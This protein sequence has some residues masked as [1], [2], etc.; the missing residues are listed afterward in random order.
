D[1]RTTKDLLAQCLDWSPLLDALPEDQKSVVQPI[2]RAIA[3]RLVKQPDFK[4]AL[5]IDGLD[6]SEYLATFGL[7]SLVHALEEVAIPIILTVRREFWDQKPAEME[8]FGR[9]F[10]K[11]TKTSGF[12]RVDLLPWND[13]QV[14]SVIEHQSRMKAGSTA[15]EHLRELADAVRSGQYSELYGDIPYRPLFLRMIIDRVEDEGLR[16]TRRAELVRAWARAKVIRDILA[17][18]EEG[19]SGRLAVHKKDV[20]L[21][22]AIERSWALMHRAALAMAYK[23][24]DALRLRGACSPN[25]LANSSD[26]IDATAIVLNT[27]LVPVGP[28]RH[29][30]AFSHRIFQE[31][32]LAEVIFNNDIYRHLELPS[33]IIAW[34]EELHKELDADG[35]TEHPSATRIKTSRWSAEPVEMT[36]EQQRRRALTRFLIDHF[37]LKEL[38][39]F[40]IEY[41]PQ[42]ESRLPFETASRNDVVHILVGALYRRKLVNRALIERLVAVRPN[43]ASDLHSLFPFQ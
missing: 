10:Q 41:Y 2:L 42:I 9:H 15:G 38:S 28:N 17:P 32:F 7:R 30:V 25:E 26:N 36:D 23:E 5:I 40:V 43:L 12:S 3:L 8:I 18:C 39:A 16:V 29:L 6:E 31:F 35:R 21:D 33:E 14:L 11:K 4:A 1:A 22:A 37:N 19:G 13:T 34:L 24:G 20:S 27:L